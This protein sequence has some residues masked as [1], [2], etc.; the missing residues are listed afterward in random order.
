MQVA[1]YARVSTPTQQQSD[2]IESQLDML[3]TYAH[4]HGYEILPEHRFLD[5]G[6]S[7]AQLARPELERLRDGVQM[8]EID[9]VLILSPDRLARN[10]AHQ[11]LLLEEFKRW[12]CEVIFVQTPFHDTPQGH[13]LLQ[14]Q[15][16]MAEYEREQIKERT[17]RGRLAKARK[18]EFIPWAYKAYGLRYVHKQ[19]GTLPGVEIEPR[20]AQVVGQMFSWLVDEQLTTR[21]ITKR[22][23]TQG[24]AT[25]TGVNQVWQPATVQG[26]LTN[27]LY[28]GRGYYNKSQPA[29]PKARRRK[30]PPR[31][32]V[33]RQARKARPQSE[34]IEA[35]APAIISEETFAKAQVQ[36]AENRQ[37]AARMYQ[38]SSRRYLLRTLI[39]CGACGLGMQ[40]LRQTG[41]GRYEYL[42]YECKGNV[43][44]SVGRATRCNAR[45]VRADRL[46]GV[47]WTSLVQLLQQPE[48]LEKE[49]QLY[50]DLYQGDQSQFDAQWARLETQSARLQ[51]QLQRLLDAYQHELIEL[52]ELERRRAQLVTQ[53]AAV[54]KQ[55]QQ[56][57]FQQRQCLRWE[58]V[59]EGIEAFNQLLS[60]RLDTLSFEERQKLVQL[61]IEK[62]VI[63]SNGDVEIHHLLPTGGAT[64]GSQ[65]GQSS[66]MESCPTEEST[67]YR[68][69][70]EHP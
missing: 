70:L 7:G 51:R 16:M 63:F 4:Q 48:T 3:Q 6:V 49:Y 26:I 36:L 55:C 8:G 67:F 27:P 11:W 59:V 60:D 29:Q 47:V 64:S 32:P 53:Q 68:L 62:V 50:Q 45:R 38:P 66:A 2:T 13:L 28:T 14:V 35:Q 41:G 21:Q 42:Y 24:I 9:A 65:N 10:Y 61:L 1:L 43:P 31:P 20:E 25:K 46:D 57:Q 54:D 19:F 69:R 56:L 37:K 40:A 30:F 33:K 23:N 5:N 39:R 44:L 15:G 18:G 58:Q 34:W 22:L 52:E 12:H 17:R